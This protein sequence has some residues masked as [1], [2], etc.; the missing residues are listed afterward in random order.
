MK[1]PELLRLAFGCV[2]FT[3]GG[4]F[5]ERF[6]NLCAARGINLHE[7]EYSAEGLHANVSLR[8]FPKLR[9]IVRATGVKIRVREKRGLPFFWRRHRNRVGL[10]A[11]AVFFILFMSVMNH[12]VWCIRAEG[13]DQFS[14]GQLISAAEKVGLHHGVYVPRFDEEKASRDLQHLFAGKLSWAAVNI[15]GSLAVVEVRDA[16]EKK[17]NDATKEPC[18]IVADFDGVILSTRTYSGVCQVAAGNGVK[19]GDLLISGVIEGGETAAAY[20]RAQG[21]FTAL[22][23]RNSTVKRAKNKTEWG[24]SAVETRYRLY[25]FG[26]DIPLYFPGRVREDSQVFLRRC[27][28]EYA[29]L[30]LPFG[31]SQVSICTVQDGQQDPDRCH[32]RA[33]QEYTDMTYESYKNTR[34]ISDNLAVSVHNNDVTVQGEYECIDFIG[35]E[36]A[37]IA[38]KF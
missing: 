21:V 37:I 7:V 33:V 13:S 8:D 4:G 1:L 9:S 2:A 17:E 25:F 30:T 10:L 35:E 24:Y 11:G 16:A 31:Y 38:E 15:K 12:F 18:N 34:I 3:A 5:P 29:G 23:S 32:I 14:E 19:K 6:I 36:K 26:L 22:H 28:A 27:F 20:Y